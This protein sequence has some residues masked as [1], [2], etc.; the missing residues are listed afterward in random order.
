M[1][2]S[3]LWLFLIF[4][5]HLMIGGFLAHWYMKKISKIFHD[6]HGRNLHEASAGIAGGCMVVLWEF[7]LPWELIN[8]FR[9]WRE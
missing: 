6:A 3:A 9:G 4:F 5:L 2:S 7:L 8:D 1:G